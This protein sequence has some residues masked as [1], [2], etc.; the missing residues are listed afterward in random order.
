MGWQSLKVIE[1]GNN[2]L[3]GNIPK[4]MGLLGGLKSLHLHNNHL[5]NWS[6][7]WVADLS[8]NEFQGSIPTWMAEWLPDL[9]VLTLRSNKL[10]GVIPP[11][12]CQLSSLQVLDLA[13]NNLSEAIPRCINKFI[14]MSLNPNE[15]AMNA[16][17]SLVAIFAFAPTGSIDFTKNEV[18]VTKGRIYQYDKTLPLVTSLDLSKNNISGKIPKE[19]TTL[20]GLRFLNLSGNHITGVI[21]KNIG[22]MGLLESIDLSKNQLCGEIPPSIFIGNKLCGPLLTKNHSDNG[23]TPEGNE[24][25]SKGATS[26]VDWFYVFMA[27]GFAVGFWGISTPILFIKTWSDPNMQPSFVQFTVALKPLQR[28]VIPSHFLTSKVHLSHKRSREQCAQASLVHSQS[29]NLTVHQWQPTSSRNSSSNPPPTFLQCPPASDPKPPHP[30]LRGEINPSLLNLK[31]LKHLDLSL[32]DFGG[33][34]IPFFI[35]SLA[36]LRYLNLSEAGFVGT[37]PHQLGNLSILRFLSLKSFLSMNVEKLQWLLDLSHLEHL[38]L[39]YVNLTKA[40]NWL[41]VIIELPSLVELHLSSCELH[42]SPHLLDA[43]FTSLVALDLSFNFF[44]S[45]IPRWI[46]SLSS[47]ISLDLYWC[48]FVDRLEGLFPKVFQNMTSLEYLDLS[49]NELEGPFP[50][51]LSNLTSLRHLD[52]SGNKLEGSL[53]RILGNICNLSF[54]DLSVNNFSGKLLISSSKCAV[55]ALEIL[56]LR[57]NQLSGHLPDE[58]EQFK[59]LQYLNLRN[60]FLSGS[61]PATIG[62]LSSLEYLDLERN[63]LNG[64]LPQSFGHL[65]KLQQLYVSNNLLEDIVSEIHF[66]NLINLNTIY[67]SGNQL[68]LKVSRDWIPPF[69]LIGVEL[70]SWNLGP[71]FPIWLRPQKDLVILDLSYTGILDEIPIWFWNFSSSLY[72]VDLLHNQIHGEIPYLFIA[73]KVQYIYLNSNHFSGPL[74]RIS[75]NLEDLDFSNNSFSGDISHFLCDRKDKQK[76]T[77]FS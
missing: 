12:L 67:A 20:Q 53:P 51:L 76:K 4:S 6:N 49:L 45:L 40:P 19:L 28:L 57:F 16:S 36:S 65:S 23:K 69:Q 46:L 3:T 60:N 47:L 13:N 75:S 32:N 10:D 27:L 39:S 64:T 42:H 7:L 15:N 77:G 31:H 30:M 26:E 71:K 8:K 29:P 56:S 74:P 24:G 73:S 70:A 35:G 72:F 37:I 44:D 62:R 43:K 9:I 41:Q 54:V 66:T 14:A 58:L 68:T 61:I 5:S 59:V 1:M 33:M 50:V 17:P 48:L 38:D 2:N 52:L 63:Q 25:D 18:L 22:N 21:P 11:E 55:C 34:P